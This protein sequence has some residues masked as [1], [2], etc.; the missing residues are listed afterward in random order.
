MAKHTLG[1]NFPNLGDGQKFYN[2][3]YNF[4]YPAVPNTNVFFDLVDPSTT[5]YCVP[6]NYANGASYYGIT[7]SQMTYF[8][9]TFL[10]SFYTEIVPSYLPTNPLGPQRF[11][12][13]GVL[14]SA[15]PCT[16][17]A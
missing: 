14:V 5:G 8:C 6:A 17:L 16:F 11:C 9:E 4:T 13:G 1:N 10:P 12:G 15:D 7:T 2:M 3:I